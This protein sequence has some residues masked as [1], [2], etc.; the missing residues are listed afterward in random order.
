[1]EGFYLGR[2]VSLYSGSSGNCTYIG[3]KNEGILIDIG[4]NCKQTEIALSDADI[5]P[6]AVKAIFITH[7]HSDHIAGLRV[8]TKKH[9]IPVFTTAKTAE[10][11][12]ATGNI[13]AKAKISAI[14]GEISIGNFSVE[15]FK[16]SHDSVDCCGFSVFHG[17]KKITVATDLG[18]IS[19]EVERAF[20]GSEVIVIESNYDR[21]MLDFGSYPYYLKRRIKSDIG[22]L[23]NDDCA[24]FLPSVVQSGCMKIL[25]AHLSSQNNTPPIARM[26]SVNKLLSY[27][28]EDNKDY[29]LK[30]AR[31]D[32]ITD[33][34]IY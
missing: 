11:I 15:A 28:M 10:Q 32:E 27:G 23:S 18:F 29:L 4:K 16:T 33:A 17:T 6:S 9:G 25:I 14:D 3:D 13:D 1:M 26:E 20:C 31:R 24:E 22:H 34:I 2:V 5:A 7:E 12:I 19:K 8:F 30:T 21:G